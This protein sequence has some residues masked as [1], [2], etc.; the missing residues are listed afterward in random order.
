[1]I[2]LVNLKC[3]N[4]DYVIKEIMDEMNDMIYEWGEL[5]NKLQYLETAIRDG[6]NII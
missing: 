3:A 1:M 5:K 2:K 6:G 4:I